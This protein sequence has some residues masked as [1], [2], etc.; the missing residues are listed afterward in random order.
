MKE[1]E[2]LHANSKDVQKRSRGKITQWSIT[3]LYIKNLREYECD[4]CEKAYKSNK[5]LHE[6]K[7]IAHI[8]L[9]DYVCEQCKSVFKSE[10]YLKRHVKYVHNKTSENLKCGIC[11][12]KFLNAK[13]LRAHANQAHN[14]IT[15]DEN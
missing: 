15:K 4:S 11:N 14:Q 6:H 10:S 8:N 12:K 1:K 13:Y 7:L 5:S 3:I 2:I 9:Q